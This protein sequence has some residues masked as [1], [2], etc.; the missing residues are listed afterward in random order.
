MS[1]MT[2]PKYILALFAP[3]SQY[4]A[5]FFYYLLPT[6]FV[7]LLWIGFACWI[8]LL[9]FS[10]DAL[11]RFRW[12]ALAIFAAAWLVV[13]LPYLGI[14]RQLYWVHVLGFRIH[15]SP[16]QEYLARCRLT[17]FVEKDVKQ[18]VGVCEDSG[19]ALVSYVVFYDTTGELVLPLRER[20]PEWKDAMWHYP[21]KGVLRD[22]EDRAIHLSGNFYRVGILATEFDGDS[23]H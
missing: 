2:S 16:I 10:V 13:S 9:F 23:A 8:P 22:S 19:D 1:L 15:T 14:T 7:W 18:T 6:V 20:T 12:R 3:I 21:P 11:F 5:H 17:E 4:A